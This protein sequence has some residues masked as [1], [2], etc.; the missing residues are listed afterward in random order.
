MTDRPDREMVG[1]E[2][3]FP[4]AELSA[5]SFDDEVGLAV[6]YEK[7]LVGKALLAIAIAFL[8]LAIRTYFG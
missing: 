7:G 1:G 5:P 2:A 8:V 4:G 6:S 3:A